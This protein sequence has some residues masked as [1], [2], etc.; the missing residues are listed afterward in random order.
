MSK[1]QRTSEQF[2]LKELKKLGSLFTATRKKTTPLGNHAHLSRRVLEFMLE[3]ELMLAA[4]EGYGNKGLLR[5][6]SC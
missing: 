1:S 4:V 3:F 6:G 2:F 5:I